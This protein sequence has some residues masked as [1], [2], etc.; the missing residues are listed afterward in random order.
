[1]DALKFPFKIK[2]GKIPK[3]DDATDEYAA[4][5]IMTA[6]K[7]G[8][9]ELLITPQFGTNSPEFVGF[10][11]FGLYATTSTYFADIRVEEFTLLAGDNG[12]V[13]VKVEFSRSE[14]V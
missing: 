6:I 1:M 3:I 9:G 2:N 7:T 13:N 5:C 11:E 14:E 8:L 4:Q 10:D 12:A